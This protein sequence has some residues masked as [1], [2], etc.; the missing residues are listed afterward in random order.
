MERLNTLR[1]EFEQTK[2]R[3]EFPFSFEDFDQLN[4]HREAI[5]REAQALAKRLNLQGRFW[6]SAAA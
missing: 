5:L 4:Q 1:Q 3:L 6:F 2:Q